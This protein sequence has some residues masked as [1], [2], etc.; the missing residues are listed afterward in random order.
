MVRPPLADI[1][2][3]TRSMPVI[4]LSRSALTSSRPRAPVDKETEELETM[5]PKVQL[6]TGTFSV[7]IHEERMRSPQDIILWNI[8]CPLETCQ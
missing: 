6:L 2:A 5:F 1:K 8:A 3:A 4:I 7:G